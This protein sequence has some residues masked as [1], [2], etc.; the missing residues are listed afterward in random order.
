MGREPPTEQTVPK[1]FL[2]FAK[3]ALKLVSRGAREGAAPIIQ[4]VS[5]ASFDAEKLRRHVKEGDDSNLLS[6]DNR[7]EALAAGGFD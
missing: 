2:S 1:L 4:L 3:T 6:N 5:S 7:D